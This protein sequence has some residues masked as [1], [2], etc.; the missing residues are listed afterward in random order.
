[1]LVPGTVVPGIAGALGVAG[2]VVAGGVVTP[3]AGGVVGA[4]GPGVARHGGWSPGGVAVP[5]VGD[6][7]ANGVG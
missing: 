1:L 2:A 4:P 7:G 3:V 6:C 5:L